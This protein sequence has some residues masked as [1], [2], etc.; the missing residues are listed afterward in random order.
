MEQNLI[1]EDTNIVYTKTG[2]PYCERTKVFLQEHDISFEERNK[3]ENPA[4]E[5]DLKQLAKEY[6]P[7]KERITVPQIWLKGQ[8]VGGSDDLIEGG[9]FERIFGK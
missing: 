7:D 2:C 6:F 8:Y 9:G 4:F 3:T 1:G 5:E